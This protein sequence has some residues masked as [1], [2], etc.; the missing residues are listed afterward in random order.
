MIAA[1]VRML[2]AIEALRAGVPSRDVVSFFP[3]VQA[4][5]ET[6]WEKSLAASS[7]GANGQGLLLEGD[8]GTG[9]THWLE[10]MEHLALEANFICS[11]VVVNKETPLHDARKILAAAVDGARFRGGSGPALGEIS[12][13]YRAESAPGYT[14]LFE[15]VHGP[16]RDPRLALTL[17]LFERTRDEETRERVLLEWAG[18]PMTVAEIKAGL[19]DAGVTPPTVPKPRKD[20]ALEKLEFVARLVRSAGYAG[21]ALLLDETEMVS[22]YSLLQRGRSYANL[23]LLLGATKQGP[24]GLSCAATITK[25]YAGQVLYGRKNDMANLVAKMESSREAALAATALIGMRFIERSGVD[26]RPPGKELVDGLFD[27]CRKLY[28]E[29]YDWPA[30]PLPDRREYSTSTSMRQHMR[31]WI[32]AWDLLRLYGRH[33]ETIVDNLVIS[34]EED[35]DIQLESPTEAARDE[36]RIV[37]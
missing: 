27:Q 19:R 10:Y 11:T 31:W 35:A 28:S 2:R 22:K 25:D 1:K 34:Y 14:K 26:L 24:A 4:D 3:P 5:I 30:G 21:W 32:N 18:T 9:K 23:A 12:H 33:G 37:L 6:R 8:F 7:S 29:A 13:H 36:P 16:D 15:W 17:L 20:N